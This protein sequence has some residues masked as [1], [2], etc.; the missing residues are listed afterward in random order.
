MGMPVTVAI[1]GVSDRSL[2][3][4]VFVWFEAVDRRF[5]TWRTD[6]E[7]SD[8]NAGRHPECAW[9][10]EMREVLA[11]CDRTRRESDGYFDARTPNGTIDPSGVVKGWAIRKAAA[12]IERAG[13]RNYYVDAG[14][15]IQSAGLSASGRPWRVGVQSPFD[16]SEIVK[17]VEPRGRG[18][19]TSG[20]YVRGR[21]IYVPGSPDRTVDDVVSLTVI[22]PDVL[23]ADRFAT[24]AFAM[25]GDGIAFIE[26]TPG[27][28]GFQV[29]SDRTA[30]ATTGFAEFCPS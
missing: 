14:G 18:V 15:D 11:L 7:I 27:L 28:E 19:A 6:S 23:E 26:R 2:V 22:G 17:I 21:H 12:I 29:M 3:D 8:I 16:R 20:S 24:A 30:V 13:E 10:G 4:Q 1:S 9:S 25:G 5:S